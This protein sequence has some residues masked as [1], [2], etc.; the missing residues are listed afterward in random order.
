MFVCRQPM[1]ISVIKEKDFLLSHFKT[2]EKF[3]DLI[4]IIQRAS[5]SFHCRSELRIEKLKLLIQ[6]KISPE[7][8]SLSVYFTEARLTNE[9]NYQ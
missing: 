9:S 8:E 3:F 5:V 7:L 2:F 6:V 1:K 4:V